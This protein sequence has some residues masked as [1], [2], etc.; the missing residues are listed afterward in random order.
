M[1]ATLEFNLPE[2]QRTIWILQTMALTITVLALC[3]FD[4][5][6][7]SEYKYNGKEEMYAVREKLNQIINDNNVKL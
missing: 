7:R 2:D 6:L 4:Q 1:K 5:W 3:E